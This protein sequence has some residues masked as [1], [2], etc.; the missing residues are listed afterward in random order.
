MTLALALTSFQGCAALGA[1]LLAHR[2]GPI[3]PQPE[4]RARGRS[5]RFGAG[6]RSVKIKWKIK[7]L[8]SE[9]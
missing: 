1:L 6:L 2:G 9:H 3:A 5:A 7:H 8:P 4:P